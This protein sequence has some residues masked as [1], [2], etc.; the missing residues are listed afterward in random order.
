MAKIL[1][2]R[3]ELLKAAD[4]L[5]RERFEISIRK[6]MEEYRKEENRQAVLQ[7]FR[8]LASRWKEHH[9]DAA[10]E[11]AASLGIT[12]LFSSILTGSYELKLIL[13]G[14]EFWLE[15]E[16][17]EVMWKPPHFFEYFEEDMELIIKKL[18]SSFPRLCRAEA[19]A[20]RMKYA[21]YYQAAICK[22]CEDLSEEI[23]ESRELKELSK[24]DDFCLFFGGYQREGEILFRVPPAAMKQELETDGKDG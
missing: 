5:Q 19:D 22:L 3:E 7:M 15:E 6:L 11:K 20:L 12:Y 17:L 4:E 23:M 1:E 9:E 24:T 2:R 14:K 13:M 8:E 18:K 21:D 10:G 16:P